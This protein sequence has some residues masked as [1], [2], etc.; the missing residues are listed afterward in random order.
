[1]LVYIHVPFCRHK[2]NYCTF[3]SQV[4]KDNETATYLT[5]LLSEIDLWG[6]RLG[7]RQTVSSIFIGGGTP[8][9]LPAAAIGAMLEALGKSF[10]LTPNLEISLEANPQS[11]SGVKY[12]SD[13]L[14]MGVRRLSLGAQSLDDA[15]LKTLGRQHS[16]SDV[17]RA[18]RD[19]REAGFGNINL[20][21]MWG[22]P[23]QRLRHFKEELKY[24]TLHLKPDHLSCYGLTLEPGTRLYEQVES[25]KL[26]LP[27]EKEQGHMFLDGAE[28]LQESGYMQYEISNFARIGF[29][30]KHNLGYWAGRDY[31]GL[32]PGAVSTWQG[33]R[34]TNSRD[35]AEYTAAISGKQ[36]PAEAEELDLATKVRELI[37]LSLRTTKGLNAATYRK[38]T[39][40]DFFK[41]NQNFINALH[42]KNLIRI[43][44]GHLSLTRSGMLVS[45]TIM[46]HLFEALPSL[47][48]GGQ[49]AAAIAGSEAKPEPET[50]PEVKAQAE[51]TLPPDIKNNPVFDPEAEL[52]LE[53]APKFLSGAGVTAGQAMPQP[54]AAFNVP[55]NFE[56]DALAPN[57]AAGPEGNG[58][59][60]A[61]GTAKAASTAEP[62]SPA[63]SASPANPTKSV[64]PGD[65]VISQATDAAPANPEQK[66]GGS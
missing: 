16:S 39:G 20:D 17:I 2:C 46:G 4:P 52:T 33:R 31:L 29:Q 56:P 60:K 12:F 19:A 14:R 38:L 5:S 61:G 47:G 3:Y 48:P 27:S 50:G 40:N 18:V 59:A 8:S 28:F 15:L 66:G 41:E 53:I 57:S 63:K 62:V 42:S 21:I 36:M 55:L 7:R 1:M 43:R 30:C 13:L 11:T 6:Q 58:L 10:S 65:K 54:E 22:L 26:K 51:P 23:G 44:N 25:G 45:N 37:M 24:I 35:L 32:G 64:N 34:W 49:A 9:L